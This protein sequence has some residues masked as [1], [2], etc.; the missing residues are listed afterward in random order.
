MNA[1]VHTRT[2]KSGNSIA[3]RLPKALGIEADMEMA[4]ERR[5]GEW[6]LRAVTDKAA[7]KV[8]WLKMLDELRELPKPPQI[9]QREPIIFPVHK[10]L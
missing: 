6:V 10:S 2:F 9:Q 8:R 3:V 4:V 5:G 1:P 7:E